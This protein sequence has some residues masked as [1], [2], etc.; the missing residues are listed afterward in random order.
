MIDRSVLPDSCK[1]LTEQ[2]LKTLDLLIL[3]TAGMPDTDSACPFYICSHGCLFYYIFTAKQI[4]D[5]CR[6]AFHF[7]CHD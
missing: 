2:K 4:C 5:R 3:D 7:E 1:A 6:Q